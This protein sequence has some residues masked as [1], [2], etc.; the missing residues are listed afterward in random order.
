MILLPPVLPAA[1]SF[2]AAQSLCLHNFADY[3]MIFLSLA[4]GA[5]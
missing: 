2:M 1:V 5:R 3:A 4:H